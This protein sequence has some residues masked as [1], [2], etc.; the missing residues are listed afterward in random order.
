MSKPSLPSATPQQEKVNAFAP[1]P[2]TRKPTNNTSSTGQ[3]KSNR[4]SMK[5][6]WTKHKEDTA[7][8]WAKADMPKPSDFSYAWEPKPQ[9]PSTSTDVD[10]APYTIKVDPSTLNIRERPLNSFER[11]AYN[12][13]RRRK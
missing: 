2:T 7:K 12:Y 5:D 4:Q 6:R 1:Q 10:F 9:K 11:A 8:A 13:K 3:S